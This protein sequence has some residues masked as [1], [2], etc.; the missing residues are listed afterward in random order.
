VILVKKQITSAT[1]KEYKN[2]ERQLENNINKH[3]KHT[4]IIA[5]RRNDISVFRK[6]ISFQ[7]SADDL[8]RKI[9]GV[10]KQLGIIDIKNQY[11]DPRR[12]LG[13]RGEEGRDL[14][15]VQTVCVPVNDTTS[16]LIFACAQTE[17]TERFQLRNSNSSPEIEIEIDRLFNDFLAALDDASRI[18]NAS[19]IV[20]MTVI[21]DVKMLAIKT[22]QGLPCTV[23]LTPEMAIFTDPATGRA[24]CVFKDHA[25]EEIVFQTKNTSSRIE[26]ES[27]VALVSSVRFNF[28]GSKGIL[29]DWLPPISFEVMK[30]SIRGWGGSL[31]LWGVAS[32]LL[33]NIFDPLWGVLSIIL[34][35]IN[36]FIIHRALFV[37]NGLLLITVGIMNIITIITIVSLG[38]SNVFWGAFGFFQIGWGVQELT[39]FSKYR[40][41]KKEKSE[42]I[43]R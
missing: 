36:L 39:K 19:N 20:Q 43:K 41:T 6:L 30:K 34:G 27:E 33:S 14:L 35:V 3:P 5:K 22:L 7:M 13:S 40:N 1:L 23:I 31:I 37:I 24:F 4:T 26:M 42:E 25:R 15:N 8:C 32:I 29:I 21:S 18:E 16:M 28:A 11:G 10:F 12:I 9:A 38:G 17:N 2:R